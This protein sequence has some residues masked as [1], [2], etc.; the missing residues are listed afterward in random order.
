RFQACHLLPTL[1]KLNWRCLPASIGSVT[2]QSVLLCSIWS[3]QPRYLSGQNIPSV[4]TQQST[5]DGFHGYLFSRVAFSWGHHF[6]M[7]RGAS[8]ATPVDSWLLRCIAFL[9]R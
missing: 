3:A 8:A 6:G 4:L 5:G 2:K 7:W 9:P 1:R